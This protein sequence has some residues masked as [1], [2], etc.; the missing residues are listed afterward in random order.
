VADLLGA[1]KRYVGV[2][3]EAKPFPSATRLIPDGTTFYETDT[4]RTFLFDGTTWGLQDD[5]GERTADRLADLIE[6]NADI[7]TELRAIRS[8]LEG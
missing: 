5:A 4:R 2:S 7:L 6:L 8:A 1:T 3:T